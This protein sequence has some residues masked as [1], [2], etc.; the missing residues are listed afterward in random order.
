MK[1]SA[2]VFAATLIVGC[3]SSSPSQYVKENG[4]DILINSGN[5]SALI[6]R[7]ENQ[8]QDDPSATTRFKLAS[9]HYK[10]GDTEAATFQLSQIS[11]RELD[12]AELAL[13]RANVFLDQGK[14]TLA[15]QHANTAIRKKKGLGEAHNL[16]GLI[17][18]EQGKFADATF[19]FETARKNH[20]NDAAIKNNLAMMAILKGD[21][22][23]AISIL[24]PLVQAGRADDKAKANLLLAYAKA[25][26]TRAF[27]Q[28][29]ANSQNDTN[30]A[31]K[32]TGLRN[33]TL[34]ISAL[35]Y[36]DESTPASVAYQ[37]KPPQPIQTQ[38]LKTEATA[39]IG[40]ATDK[41]E[42]PL[43]TANTTAHT[44]KTSNDQMAK[45]RA[46]LEEANAKNAQ[47]ALK[48]KKRAELLAE[49]KR[50]RQLA[51]SRRLVTH[52]EYKST[53]EGEEYIATSDFPMGKINTEY[54][55]KRR[56]WVFDIE[57]AKDFTTKRRR[58]YKEG[59][60]KKLVL[61][62]H[63][64]FVRIVLEMRDDKQ[65]NPEVWVEGNKLFIR[66]KA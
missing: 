28:L 17:L 43:L 55:E 7:Y 51:K 9:A 26:K 45:L 25:G 62:E 1:A 64:N 54:L 5:Y 52:V 53:A 59:P 47:R 66:W 46:K 4:E 63:E 30:L 58:Y 14:L 20:Y 44:S 37:T 13:L 42:A 29:L 38:K 36:I 60:A 8:L 19:A 57:G 27:S 33:T 24:S 10:L 18:A 16:K 23:E 12:S 32:F 50:K 22:N 56:K 41:L 2:Y 61:G 11:P 48:E 21:Y 40:K 34:N 35:T 49:T 39:N 3:T 31:E 15:E 65:G 6:K